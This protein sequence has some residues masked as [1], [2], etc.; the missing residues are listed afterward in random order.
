MSQADPHNCFVRVIGEPFSFHEKVFILQSGTQI[1]TRKLPQQ[2][3]AV[4]DIINAF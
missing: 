3:I 4:M 1:F 2:V